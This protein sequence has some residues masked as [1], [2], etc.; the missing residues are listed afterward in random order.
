MYVESSPVSTVVHETDEKLLLAPELNRKRFS[1]FQALTA[2][3]VCGA[4]DY[5]TLWYYTLWN[6]AYVTLWFDETYRIGWNIP[7]GSACLECNRIQA[8]PAASG[9]ILAEKHSQVIKT[10]HNDKRML[11]CFFIFIFLPP[12]Q[13]F[14]LIAFDLAFTCPSLLRLSPAPKL[15]TF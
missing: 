2:E 4:C 8:N 14:R 7:V 9:N 10:A 6:K 15:A 12:N 11:W 13:I 1:A 3:D 5:N